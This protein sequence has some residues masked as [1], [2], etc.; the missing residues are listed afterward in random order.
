MNTSAQTSTMMVKIH[1]DPIAFIIETSRSKAT[2]VGHR[3]GFVAVVSAMPE[4]PVRRAYSR[5]HWRAISTLSLRTSSI[6][7]LNTLRPGPDF[8]GDAKAAQDAVNRLQP[9]LDKIVA[10]ANRVDDELAHAIN[11]AGGKEPIP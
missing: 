1:N 3:R 7:V 10:E 8:R 5:S 4:V 6:Y 9:Q 2:V 11:M